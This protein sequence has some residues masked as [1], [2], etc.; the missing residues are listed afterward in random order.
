[1]VTGLY[2]GFYFDWYKEYMPNILL[3]KPSVQL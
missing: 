1:M 2:S 3:T